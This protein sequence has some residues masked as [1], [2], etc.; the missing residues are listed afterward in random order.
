MLRSPSTLANIIFGQFVVPYC[1][2]SRSWWFILPKF[3]GDFLIREQH[4][5]PSEAHLI[6][7]LIRDLE[8]VASADSKLRQEPFQLQLSRQSWHVMALDPC[9]YLHAEFSWI[10]H[11]NIEYQY[12]R[13]CSAAANVAVSTRS[14][15]KAQK[16]CLLPSTAWYLR[17]AYDEKKINQFCFWTPW[18]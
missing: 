17:F 18:W 7:R 15:I 1:P 2:P 4:A 6:A 14:S 9:Y 13:C 5:S 3:F 8:L 16:V 10:I 11:Y 12:T